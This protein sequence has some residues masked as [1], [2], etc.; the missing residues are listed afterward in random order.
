MKIDMAMR[1]WIITYFF[2]F[3]KNTER[4]LIDLVGL[5]TLKIRIVVVNNV[6]ILKICN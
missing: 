5:E 1:T 2:S 6:D 3:P 4:Y